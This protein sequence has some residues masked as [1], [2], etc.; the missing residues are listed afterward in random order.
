MRAVF[1]VTIYGT[2][3]TAEEPPVFS[4]GRQTG[5]DYIKWKIS[6][7]NRLFVIL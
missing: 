6:C 7:M 3:E 4:A 5:E 2:V 1:D